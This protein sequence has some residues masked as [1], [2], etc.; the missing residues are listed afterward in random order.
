MPTA[1]AGGA[2]DRMTH[3]LKVAL[4]CGVAAVAMAGP[5]AAQNADTDIEQVVVTGT[6]IRGVAPIGSNL[7]T[8]D[9]ETIR[10]SGAN[11]MQELLQTVTSIEDAG[12]AP[13]GQGGYAFYAPSIHQLASSGANATL[14]LVNGFRLPGGGSQAYSETDPDII[15]AIAVQ[16]VEVLADGA[17]SIYGSDA[18]A[19][20][21]N[22]ITRK[23]YQGLEI[24]AQGGLGNHYSTATFGLLGGTSWS[25]GSFMVAGNYV[26][27]SNLANN[28][29][30]FLS[31]GD[32]TPLGGTNLGQTFGCPVAAIAVPGS[33]ALYLTPQSTTPVA[34]TLANRNCNISQYG[35][36]LP[37]AIRE[38]VLVQ[39]NQS[40]R[41]D[42]DVSMM[43]DVSNL[44]TR[45]DSPPGSVSNVTV[46]GPGN[47][48]TGQINPFFQAPAGAPGVNQES[49]TWV[50]LMGNGPNGTDYGHNDTRETVGLGTAVITYRPSENWEIKLSDALGY[51]YYTDFNANRFCTA[52]AYLALNGTAQSSASTTASDVSG[53]NSVTLNLPL[54]RANALDVWHT[55]AANLTSP[56]A[57]QNLYDGQTSITDTNTFNQLKLETN[58]PLFDLP[59]GPLKFAAGAELIFYHLVHDVLTANGGGRTRSNLS[60]L[61]YH[62]HRSVY[63]G[64]AELAIPVVSPEMGLAFARRIDLDISGRYDRYSDV[65]PAFNPK[66]AGNW[67]VVDGL[68]LLANYSTSFVAPPF[69][70]LGDLSLGGMRSSGTSVTYGGIAIP[71]GPYPTVTQ[72]PGCAAAVTSCTIPSSDPGL[73]R[74]YGGVLNGMKPQTGNGWS[75]GAEIAPLA[76]PGFTANVTLWNTHFKGG[77]NSGSVDLFTSTPALQGRIQLYPGCATQAQIDAFTRV[78]Q[79][80]IVNGTLPP[81]VYY[82]VNSDSANI[83]NLQI[84]GL[85][86][87]LG[88]QFDTD[89]MGSFRISDGLTEYLDYR[90]N[91]GGGPW[92]SVLNTTGLNISFPSVQT[93]M[94]GNLGWTGGPYSLDFFVNFTGGYRYAGTT[95]VTPRTYDANG[96]YKAGGDIVKSNTTLDLHGAFNFPDGLLAGDQI[97]LD[98]KNVFDTD[99][100]FLNGNTAGVG[101]GGYGFNGFI[102][103]PIGRVISL[104]V[105]ADF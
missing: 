4:L 68:K 17:S 76:L 22:Y 10:R 52:C 82:T 6:S 96:N 36:D 48:H 88:Y 12:A 83:L 1:A 11:N 58:G 73:G 46:Y 60:D 93:Q 69:G 86:I 74:S 19:G 28:S 15:P 94:R 61:I 71:V 8:V 14:V 105:R 95:A 35:D 21:I 102:S 49:I 80:A 32:Y 9:S 5:A 2:E 20:V 90:E 66:F 29:R 67:E 7:V 51:N 72:L 44:A 34:N 30:K 45:R 84:Q 75:I 47:S 64:Y 13:Q 57:L 18:V 81:C 38:S 98:V 59:A 54:T 16:R 89:T 103:N 39:I 97:Y 26:Y 79:G 23:N 3:M 99:P 40:L 65:G 33:T 100:P 43:L 101:I 50:D 42:L 77:V 91:T 63:S 27:Q 62:F 56:A 92:Y 53:Q 104:G 41:S 70:A 55:A 25:G 37:E 24:Q 31:M 85:D 78:N 87:Q